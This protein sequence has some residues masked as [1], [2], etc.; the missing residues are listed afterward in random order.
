[1]NSVMQEF[2]VR[3]HIWFPAW[4]WGWQNVSREGFF[5]VEYLLLL[6]GIELDKASCNEVAKTQLT[7]IV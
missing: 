5:L 3:R 1:M 2:D 4:E 6:V 7:A